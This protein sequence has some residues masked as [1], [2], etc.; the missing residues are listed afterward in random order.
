MTFLIPS[1]NDSLSIKLV[2]VHP[3]KNYEA[4]K[5][6]LPPKIDGFLD[7]SIWDDAYII[8]DFIQD[9]PN[10]L[11]MPTESTE[12]KIVYDNESIYVGAFMIDSYPD[13][14][15]KHMNRRDSWDYVMMSDWFSIEIDSY[16]DHQTGF[17]FLVNFL[18]ISCNL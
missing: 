11:E 14:I 8:S 15:V 7:D 2:D 10:N 3:Q 12:I 6:I 4:I 17:E 1:E 5:V 16:H 18:F 9:E 13:G